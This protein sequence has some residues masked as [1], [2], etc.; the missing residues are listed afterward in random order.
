MIIKKSVRMKLKKEKD[1]IKRN[2]K[3]REIRKKKGVELGKKKKKCFNAYM[4][5]EYVLTFPVFFSI[6][7]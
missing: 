2:K 3:E 5:D 6:V 7:G 1:K 4:N